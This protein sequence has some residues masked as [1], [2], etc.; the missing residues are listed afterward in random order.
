MISMTSNA[1]NI[2]LEKFKLLYYPHGISHSRLHIPQNEH[3]YFVF[4]FYHPPLTS[5]HKSEEIRLK[6]GRR[7]YTSELREVLHA[8]TYTAPLKA[9]LMLLA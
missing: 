2:C 9:Y 3:Q 5:P 1:A 6:T 4:Q 7:M 8:G